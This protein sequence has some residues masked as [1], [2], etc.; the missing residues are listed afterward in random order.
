MTGTS[1]AQQSI[2]A[3]VS[4]LRLLEQG[5]TS[6]LGGDDPIMINT[7]RDVALAAVTPRL[8]SNINNGCSS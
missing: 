7:E 4:Q 5:Q 3:E 8:E 2:L 1:S 6:L